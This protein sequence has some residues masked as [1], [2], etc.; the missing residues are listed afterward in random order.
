MMKRTKQP[1]PDIKQPSLPISFWKAI[2]IEAFKSSGY[3][4][5]NKNLIKQLGGIQA[6]LFCNYIDKQQYFDERF[7]DNKGWFFLTHKDIEEQL[8]LSEKVIRSAKKGLKER[9]LIRTKM[10]GQPAKEYI[11]LNFKVIANMISPALTERVGLD[12]TER[13]GLY[14]EPLIKDKKEKEYKE[15]EKDSDT[16]LSLSLDEVLAYFP[17]DWIEDKTFHSILG[18]YYRMRKESGYPLTKTSTKLQANS[19]TGYTLDVATKALTTSVANGWRGTFPDKVPGARA[20]PKAKGKSKSRKVMTPKA[21]ID[22][23]YTGSNGNRDGS[24]NVIIA[25]AFFKETY[26]PA[27]DLLRVPD[28]PE[29]A[30]LLLGMLEDIYSQQKGMSKELA[31]LMPNGMTV[32]EHYIRWIGDNPWISDK[33]MKLFSVS[34]TLFQKFRRDEAKRDNN[35]RDPLTGKSYLW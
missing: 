29:L 24:L 6:L 34:H 22:K 30:S 17:E 4:V 31:R 25:D 10:K 13:V 26:E 9:G 8:G 23:H 32:L 21:V 12:L 35:E 14:K 27:R 15:K 28:S 33:T 18:D 11:K 19:L 2:A 20:N 7:P 1:A 16:P 3:L 5:V